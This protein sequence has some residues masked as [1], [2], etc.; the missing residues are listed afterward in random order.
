[1][2]YS[3]RHVTRFKYTA[4]VCESVMELRMQPRSDGAQRCYSFEIGVQP[5]ARIHS[6][7]DALGNFVHHFDVPENH[8]ELVITAEAMVFI[9]PPVLPERLGEYDW[10]AL[11]PDLLPA[12]AFEMLLPSHFARPSPLLGE[13]ARRIGAQRRSDPLS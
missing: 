5:R 3:I 10:K 13:L 6:H 4:P 11:N 12:D 7:R 2:Y 1:M 9:E 8:R